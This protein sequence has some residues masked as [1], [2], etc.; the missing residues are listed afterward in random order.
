LAFG[1]GPTNTRRIDIWSSD[2]AGDDVELRFIPNEPAAGPEDFAHFGSYNLRE[3][4]SVRQPVEVVSL[5]PFRAIVRSASPAFLES[6]RMFMPGYR[7][8]VD[9]LAVDVQRS[10]SGLVEIPIPKG[11][12]TVAL[13]FKGPLLLQ[14]SYFCS[15]AAWAL[16]LLLTAIGTVQA[17]GSVKN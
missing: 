15:L 17:L 16:T 9:G 12:H 14:F 4:I 8:S 10:N 5:F 13:W 7:A 6:P 1:S 2:P 11:H 3:I